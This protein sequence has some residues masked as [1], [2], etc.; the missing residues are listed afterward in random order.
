MN[1]A[2]IIFSLLLL[3]T[4]IAAFFLPWV[5]VHPSGSPNSYS[6]LSITAFPIQRYTALGLG[7]LSFILL[8]C[9]SKLSAGIALL[10]AVVA[11]CATICIW[12]LFHREFAGSDRFVYGFYIFVA[13]LGFQVLNAGCRLFCSKCCTAKQ[14]DKG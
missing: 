13:I 10:A 8:F 2:K 7:I 14:E 12:L 1:K 6:G 9:R 11:V 5:V 4:L 3:L